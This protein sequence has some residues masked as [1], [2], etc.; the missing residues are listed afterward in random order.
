MRVFKYYSAHRGRIMHYTA[1][2]SDTER[3]RRR[4]ELLTH[5]GAVVKA[6]REQ[7]G[8]SRR[9]LAER[10]ALS[11]RYLVE[12]EGGLGNISVARLAD[13]A[14]ALDLRMVDLFDLT[15]AAPRLARSVAL[16]GLRGAGKST[17]GALLAQ[18]LHV[19]FVEVDREIALRVGM[20]LPSLFEL[21]GTA[22]Y[23]RAQRECLEALLAD[24]SP[25]ILATGGSVVTDSVAFGMLR[26]ATT[27]VWLRAH[28]KHHW[29]RVIAQ[30]D[31]RP[32]KNRAD[33]MS[34]LRALL[35]ARKPF[36]SQAD[37]TI[38]TSN[39]SPTDIVR[40]IATWVT[41]P[42]ASQ[43]P[44]RPKKAKEKALP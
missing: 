2:T 27:T 8:L 9:A 3:E 4:A 22:S 43:L 10:A 1:Q 29:D 38:D 18:S 44:K 24:P 37:H 20:D 15:G 6:H 11:E 30:G 17:V 32:M 12:L 5:V 13:V 21:Y 39:L 19:P 34:E 31:V 42:T 40:R 26:A 33:A 14:A 23:Q 41:K 7:A 16:I 28:P 36:Y 25:R 35:L